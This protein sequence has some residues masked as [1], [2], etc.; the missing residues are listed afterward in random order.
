MFQRI[1]SIMMLEKSGLVNKTQESVSKAQSFTS[2]AG[3]ATVKGL[4]SKHTERRGK[5][6]WV[7]IPDATLPPSP[8]GRSQ[9]S[10]SSWLTIDEAKGKVTI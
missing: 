3:C 8:I 6:T 7:F 4:L 10:Q 1:P 2:A 9:G 5:S